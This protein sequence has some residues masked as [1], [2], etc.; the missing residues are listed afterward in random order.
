[1]AGRISEPGRHLPPSSLLQI[2]REQVIVNHI[3]DYFTWSKI[4]QPKW[5]ATQVVVGVHRA[6]SRLRHRGCNWGIKY[7]TSRWTLSKLYEWKALPSFQQSSL[8][9]I[10]VISPLLSNNDGSG[11]GE[12]E[13]I[14]DGDDDHH[15]DTSSIFAIILLIS[16]MMIFLMMIIREPHNDSN[17]EDNRDDDDNSIKTREPPAALRRHAMKTVQDYLATA[18]HLFQVIVM[19]LISQFQV[20]IL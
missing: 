1:M 7:F 17:V 4:H 9:W 2:A 8:C 19:V 10:T 6:V 15:G 16:T 14:A 5:R 18:P 13:N 20:I 12:D 11:E 3:I